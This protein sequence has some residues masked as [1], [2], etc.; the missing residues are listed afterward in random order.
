MVGDDAEVKAALHDAALDRID[1]FYMD[2]Q[3]NPGGLFIKQR[4]CAVDVA[5]GVGG[6]LVEDGDRQRAGQALIDVID[7]VLVVLQRRHHFFRGA[8]ELRALVGEGEA[9]AAAATEGEAEAGLQILDVARDGGA[10]DVQLQFRGGEAAAG[11]HGA[12]HPQ[13]AQVIVGNG[14]QQ[15]FAG[16]GCASGASHSKVS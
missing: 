3:V 11:D 16:H 14:A 2:L 4:Q 15:G 5:G 12:E 10:V 13:Q 8:V 9:T 1:G 7:V 6:G